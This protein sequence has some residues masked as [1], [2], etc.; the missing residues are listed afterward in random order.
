MSDKVLLLFSTLFSTSFSKA[1]LI[2][3]TQSKRVFESNYL[4]LTV[5]S[6]SFQ[7]SSMTNA[8]NSYT[9]VD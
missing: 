7:T 3:A 1:D 4:K 9:A 5:E 6:L 2:L 8:I